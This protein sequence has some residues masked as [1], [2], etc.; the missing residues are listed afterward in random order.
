[1][2]VSVTKYIQIERPVADTFA[3]L[4]DPATMPRWAIHNV[5]AIRPLR[6]G[7]WEMDTP[8]GKGA[9]VPHYEKH[10]GILD[11]EFLDAGEGRWWVPA[12]AVPVGPSASVYI[13]TL[14]RPEKLPADMFEA[15][16]KLMDDE[17][18]ALKACVEGQP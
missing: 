6:D 1:M 15:G 4:S 5:K 9:L 2:T 3:F 12:R 13:I 11:H 17:L 10:G 16:L 14:T 7:R 18:A 8:R